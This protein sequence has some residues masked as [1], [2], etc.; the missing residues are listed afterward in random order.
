MA[1]DGFSANP[2]GLHN[3]HGNVWEWTEDCWSDSNTGN[4][5]DGS[6]R[7]DRDCSG[8]IERGGSW[9]N[10]PSFLRAANRVW[11]APDGRSNGT[12][13]RVARTL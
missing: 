6:P 5:G 11:N 10:D 7:T 2:W 4:P 12:G 9:F 1:V 3:V 8:R 13:F